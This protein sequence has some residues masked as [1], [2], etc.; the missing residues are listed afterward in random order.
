[1]TEIIHVQVMSRGNLA[2]LVMYMLES[3]EEIKDYSVAYFNR[4]TV[5]EAL[6]H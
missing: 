3:R 2:C 4:I 5:F 1:M 6:Y